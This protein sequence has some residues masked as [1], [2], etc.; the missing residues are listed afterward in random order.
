MVRLIE[1]APQYHIL[2]HTHTLLRLSHSHYFIVNWIEAENA[3]AADR[4]AT[5]NGH[6]APTAH[7]FTYVIMSF[8]IIWNTNQDNGK[9]HKILLIGHLDVVARRGAAVVVQGGTVL[10]MPRQWHIEI[11]RLSNA[12]THCNVA[13]RE[14]NRCIEKLSVRTQLVSDEPQKG[15][16]MKAVLLS[17]KCR[18]RGKSVEWLGWPLSASCRVFVTH[19]N[20]ALSS[21]HFFLSLVRAVWSGGPLRS[22]L[23]VWFSGR[24]N[25][26]T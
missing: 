14:W 2:A 22:D 9:K 1:S 12:V 3:C 17:M 4:W 25:Y 8:V 5:G 26:F 6:R 16:K 13:W 19:R 11:R 10:S 15:R 23:C 21:V 7:L 20:V 24:W 18:E